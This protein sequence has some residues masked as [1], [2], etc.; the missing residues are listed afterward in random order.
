MKHFKSLDALRAFAVLA[1]MAHHAS[2]LPVGWVG[3]QLFFVLSGFLI[4]GILLRVKESTATFQTYLLR[5]FWRRTVRIWPLYFLYVGLF[6]FLA[7]SGLA[8]L[9]P[10][11]SP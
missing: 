9:K 1:V 7:K 8:K 6:V 10:G 11:P 5:F 3:V 4:T 2:Y